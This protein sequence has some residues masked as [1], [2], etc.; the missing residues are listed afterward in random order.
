MGRQ[1]GNLVCAV[2]WD[3]VEG[4]RLLQDN[5]KTLAHYA[6]MLQAKEYVYDMH[7]LPH[8]ASHGNQV[9]A[10]RRWKCCASLALNAKLSR[11]SA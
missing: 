8:D 2:G 6:K 3:A 1:Y 11:K 4:D 10:K 5:R 9:Q 7:H